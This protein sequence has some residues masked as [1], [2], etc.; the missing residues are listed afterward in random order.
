MTVSGHF[1]LLIQFLN[2]TESL[3]LLS[4]SLINLTR[5]PTI[6]M[7]EIIKE[8]NRGVKVRK[9]EAN[10]V[11]ENPIITR[12]P[13]PTA[14]NPKS[15]QQRSRFGLQSTIIENSISSTIRILR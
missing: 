4:V 2:Y 13:N 6:K 5:S 14:S 8:Y 12:D 10:S 3:F 9:L 15:I 7:I 1:F 11:G